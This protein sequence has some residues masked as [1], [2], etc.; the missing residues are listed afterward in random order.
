MPLAPPSSS[1]TSTTA[2]RRMPPPALLPRRASVAASASASSSSASSSPSEDMDKEAKKAAKKLAKQQK[3]EQKVSKTKRDDWKKTLSAAALSFFSTSFSSSSSSLLSVSLLP[4]H[5][6]RT[7]QNHQSPLL[8]PPRHSQKAAEAMGKRAGF[9]KEEGESDGEESADDA[10]F[11]LSLDATT[12]VRAAAATTR[13][14]NTTTTTSRA[15]AAPFLHDAVPSSSTYSRE[16]AL[17]DRS[18]ALWRREMGRWDAERRA[19]DEREAALLATVGALQREVGRLSAMLPSGSSSS[20]PPAAAAAPQSAVFV[21]PA[22]PAP[23]APVAPPVLAASAAF[24]AENGNE[25]GNQNGYSPA[26]GVSFAEHL[27]AAVAAVSSGDVLEDSLGGHGELLARGAAALGLAEKEEKERQQQKPLAEAAAAS[28]Q[29]KAAAQAHSHP[30]PPPPDLIEGSDDLYWVNA[31]QNLLDSHAM[32]CGDEEAE[33]FYF[34]GRTRAALETFQACEG[35]PETGICDE[36]TWLKLVRGDA[37][38]LR[39]LQIKAPS[40]GEVVA[41]SEA[42]REGASAAADASKVAVAASSSS[43]TSASS[44]A[45]TS[46][47]SSSHT[48]THTLRVDDDG[49]GHLQITEQDREEETVV[50]AAKAPSPITKAWPIL[51]EGD[52]GKQV[53]ALQVALESAGMSCGEDDEQWWQFGDSTHSALVTF[54]ACSALPESGV[55]D[56][57]TWR[58]LL[59]VA[60]GKEDAKNGKKPR[61]D[62]SSFVPSDVDSLTSGD[63]NDDDMLG[64]H[65]S[66]MV[67]LLGEQR[68]EKKR[69]VS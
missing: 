62:L 35:L 8:L 2:T 24:A 32:H 23:A 65:H 15:A 59:L 12:A 4:T 21:P 16:D 19:W 57:K 64:N 14:N 69:E 44:A 1:S 18:D 55:A 5:L 36:K 31:L 61:E 34:G 54:Q 43:S 47:S 58:K 40:E 42:L 51:R 63:K 17:W 46:F 52:G 67:F 3:K 30:L 56:E 26:S 11:P 37:G 27:A 33:D 22:P 13:G 53:H 66:G 49:H 38:R 10:D 41:A 28:A 39:E 29:S 50:V 68:W 45:E 48:H 60:L 9:D 20:P 7:H 25:N 6:S